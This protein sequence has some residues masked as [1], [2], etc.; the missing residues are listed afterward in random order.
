M[1]DSELLAAVGRTAVGVARVRALES[2]RPDG[3]FDDPFAAAFAHAA[4]SGPDTDDTP[5]RRAWRASIAFHIIVRTRFYDDYLR[6]A[7]AAG[8]RQVVLLGAGLDT[9]AFRLAWPAGVRLFE[10]DQSEVLRLKDQVLRERDAQPRCDRVTI[11]AD[12]RTG[13]SSALVDAGLKPSEPS[14]WLAEGLLVYLERDVVEHLV[15]DVTGLSPAGSRFAAER[16]DATAP[17]SVGDAADSGSVTR[18]WHTGDDRNTAQLL[19]A[20]GWAAAEHDLRDVAASYGRV[21]P[22]D[23]HS[24]FVTAVL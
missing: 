3:L 2:A 16:G 6:A 4:P 10:V 17:D 15:D 8:A 1:N 12:L 22:R 23:T 21:P 19:T 20:A 11:A 5:A 18:L 13:W 7:V 14:A 24:G 9:R